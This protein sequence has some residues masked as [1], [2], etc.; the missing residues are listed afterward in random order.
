M[1]S[2]LDRTREEFTKQA[3]TLGTAPAFLADRAIEP[4]VRL[5][6]QPMPSPLLDLA[7]GPGIVSAALAEAGAT[8]IGLD[9][10]PAMIAAAKERCARAGLT[11]ATF[12]E[13][14]AEALPFESASFAA[15][16]TRL[17]L[18]HFDAPGVALTE[19]RRVLQP[20]APLVVGDIV[21]SAVASEATLHDA[22]ERLRDPSHVHCLSEIE[23]QSAIEAAGFSIDAIESWDNPRTF[24][25]WA[26]I[27]EQARPI[28]PLRPVMAALA[29]SGQH[30]GIDLRSNGGQVGF[31]HRWRFVR[32]TA[33]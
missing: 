25:E 26:A 7:C 1:P 30:A 4:F 2:H 18:H 3:P 23:L 22:L 32:A 13:G 16:V 12:R 17:S 21:S 5:L 10:T 6:E 27:V 33:A 14:T 15:A 8:V 19:L 20:G 29:D 24:D 28:E 9:A 11:K 31:I